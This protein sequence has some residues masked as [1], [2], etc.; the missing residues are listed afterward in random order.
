[1][2][3]TGTCLLLGP[4]QQ[5]KWNR[6]PSSPS[7][8]PKAESRLLPS[9]LSPITGLRLSVFTYSFPLVRRFSK[10]KRFL[11]DPFI[12]I[13]ISRP[14]ES[15]AIPSEIPR[16]RN[17]RP[18]ACEP[19]RRRKVAC[20]HR[21]PICSRCIRKSAP[22]NCRYLIKG[23]L[24]TPALSPAGATRRQSAD[25]CGRQHGQPAEP[26]PPTS[27][28]ALSPTALKDLASPSDR[29][30]G[31]LGATSFPEFYR[32][33]Q[34]HLDYVAG[35]EPARD[36]LAGSNNSGIASTITAVPDAAAFETAF[37]ALRLIPKEGGASFLYARNVN[38]CDAW[39]RLAVNRLHDSLWKTLGHF[40]EGE[41]TNEA[42][43][44]MAL[45]LFQNSSK[46]LREDFADPEQWYE[47]FSGI[48][49]RWESIG[50]LFGY[51]TFGA[52]SLLENGNVEQCKSLGDHNRRKLMQ[53]YKSGTHKCLDLCRQANSNNS[54]MVL[55]IH[56]SSLTASLITGDTGKLLYILYLR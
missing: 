56:L 39:C 22:Q 12:A 42:L 40:L 28:S 3:A 11:S 37:A 51:W 5:I 17:G 2:G 32:E 53:M 14:G 43:S 21:L 30:S 18:Q 31:Y 55:L 16:R 52:T 23:Q 26:S 27:T 35:L 45:L 20:D 6:T 10:E 44:Q 38:P 25:T 50:I 13:M 48:N 49:F 1:M 34:K 36:G 29:V 41:R 54:M 33:T 8:E 7:R 4:C 47:A 15:L 9:S 46:P 19:C 24:V